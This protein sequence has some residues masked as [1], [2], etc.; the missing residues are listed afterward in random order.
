LRKLYSLRYDHHRRIPLG[1]NK[2][3]SN[4]PKETF[5]ER[6]IVQCQQSVWVERKPELQNHILYLQKKYPGIT[7]QFS[8]EEIVVQQISWRTIN[9][10]NSE[11]VRMIKTFVES[12]ILS[13]LKRNAA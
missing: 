3:Q 9:A 1:Y 7:F 13:A 8:K 11:V 6:E 5:I 4:I 2:N 10:G 12:G